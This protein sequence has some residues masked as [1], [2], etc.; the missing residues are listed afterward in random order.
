M[1]I[2]ITDAATVTNGDV[3][4]SCFSE[5]GEV[6]SYPLTE[7]DLLAQRVKDADLVLC[8]KSRMTREVM[9]EAKHLKYIG[10][11]ATG[12]N[13]IDTSA[14]KALG[15]TVCNA[16][17]Y[18]T[19][20]VAQLV[21]SFLLHHASR[22]AEYNNFV[23]QGSW[24]KSATFSPFVFEMTELAGK[25]MGIFGFGS[26]GKKVA[27]I[28]ASF[29]MKVLVTTRTVHREEE[30]EYGI[31]F[32]DF[33]TLLSSSDVITVHCPLTDRTAGLFD[34]AVFSRMKQGSYF[35]N[36]SRGGVLV[37]SA[38]AEAVKSGHLSGAGIDVLTT[39]PM[40]PD[41]P[42]LGIDAITITPHIAWAPRETRERLIG[43]VYD[44]IK[45]FLDGHPVHVVS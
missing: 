43:I 38:L 45:A 25:T 11:F 37:E 8:N 19:D 29:G 22:A 12:Y 26:I 40:L 33:D 9:E 5:F 10:L 6:I 2:V 13:N 4:L 41:C 21:F 18:S 30:A 27:R 16:G 24:I 35:I 17:S 36:T 28:A 7:P 31:C 39:E 14:A 42:L 32:V 23:Q 44:N 1:K 3:D 15:I 20:A 34:S